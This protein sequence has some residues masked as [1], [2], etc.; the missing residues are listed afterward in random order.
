MHQSSLS[1]VERVVCVR[2]L[3]A[4]SPDSKEKIMVQERV[5]APLTVI[6]DDETARSYLSQTGFSGHAA[7]RLLARTSRS[8]RDVRK[9]A[10]EAAE[11]Q[12]LKKR[13]QFIEAVLAQRLFAAYLRCAALLDK[14]AK[15]STTEEIALQLYFGCF[16]EAQAPPAV[17]KGSVTEEILGAIPLAEYRL[18][19]APL[20]TI[21]F[22][23]VPTES[24]SI[25]VPPV[26]GIPLSDDWGKAHELSGIL[27]DQTLLLAHCL[28][29]VDRHVTSKQ[30]AG[31]W[32]KDPEVH[33]LLGDRTEEDALKAFDSKLHQVVNTF[34]GRLLAGTS[35]NTVT[36]PG[37]K[38]IDSY[39]HGICGPALQGVDEQR[40]YQL[41]FPALYGPNPKVVIEAS[42]K[43]SAL[44]MKI[45]VP[46]AMQ[47]QVIEVLSRDLLPM[48][49]LIAIADKA[50]AV[51]SG[52]D[53]S[54]WFEIQ[55]SAQDWSWAFDH[56]IEL[57]EQDTVTD[58]IFQR[59]YSVNNWQHCRNDFE[60]EMLLGTFAHHG[61]TAEM[62]DPEHLLEATQ[63]DLMWQSTQRVRARVGHF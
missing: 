24:A 52:L 36:T 7:D 25:V 47:P 37:H 3:T 44:R 22:D 51:L 30:I 63:N 10:H 23:S 15:E 34:P 26:I 56:L 14:H 59:R 27:N 60:N 41:A 13:T 8:R 62:I 32:F 31:V 55:G 40:V 4:S 53:D 45:Q 57:V 35:F 46:P 28:A 12:A 29:I 18:E 33:I 11:A 54:C 5:P 58:G 16:E 39:R 38:L 61:M 6:A 9:A 21:P 20:D 50:L 49:A 2:L 43:D 42:E 48:P 19:D 17:G 1:T